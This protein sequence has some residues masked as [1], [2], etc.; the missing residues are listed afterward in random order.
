[1]EKAIEEHLLENEESLS[2]SSSGS[3]FIVIDRNNLSKQE[4]IERVVNTPT[5]FYDTNWDAAVTSLPDDTSESDDSCEVISISEGIST[6]SYTN[7]KANVDGDEN[8]DSKVTFILGNSP[9]SK[10]TDYVKQKSDEH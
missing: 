10:V 5:I 7:D 6:M 3:D 4:L 2:T 1:M 8:C 9:I